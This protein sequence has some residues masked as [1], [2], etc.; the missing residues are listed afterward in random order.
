[1]TKYYTEYLHC[2]LKFLLDEFLIMDLTIG[3]PTL[4]YIL[5]PPPFSTIVIFF[6]FSFNVFFFCKTNQLVA[7]NSLFKYTFSF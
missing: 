7:I 6:Y 5:P 4:C 2:Q 1:M 3:M